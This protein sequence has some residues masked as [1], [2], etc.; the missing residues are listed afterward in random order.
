MLFR[1]DRI[2]SPTGRMIYLSAHIDR[3]IVPYLNRLNTKVIMIIVIIL[4]YAMIYLMNML[5]KTYS[6]F[7]LSYDIL[8]TYSHASKTYLYRGKR[9]I[10]SEL[11]TIWKCYGKWSEKSETS[12]SCYSVR[13]RCHRRRDSWYRSTRE[14]PRRS[15]YHR[16]TGRSWISRTQ[17]RVSS[18][19]AYIDRSIS[20]LWIPLPIHCQDRYHWSYP[21]Y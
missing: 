18:E 1:L 6:I 15:S 7:N 4:Y 10:H 17:D 13:G 14:P 8:S 20:S 9:S 21:W 2:T 11:L 19:C 5:F 3:W 16:R 12:C